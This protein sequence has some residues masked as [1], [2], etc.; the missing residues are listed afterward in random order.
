MTKTSTLSL[1]VAMTLSGGFAACSQGATG[2]EEP[3][4][5]STDQALCNNGNG[6]GHGN[7]LVPSGSRS[8]HLEAR[9]RFNPTQPGADAENGRKKFGIAAD[10]ETEDTSEAL[11]E[12][13]SLPYG[14]T[15]TSNGR[16]CFTCHRGAGARFG[17]PAPPL[18]DSIALTDTLFTGI[19]A[20]AAGD[21][22][23]MDNL[24][25]RGLIK[26][27]PNR[28]NPQRDD[29][30]PYKQVFFWR[31]SIQ[32]VNVGFSNGFLNDGRGRVMFETARGAVFSHTQSTDGR[33]D[34]LFPVP[35]GNDMEAFMFAQV[36][37]PALN[38][39]RDPNDPMYDTLVNDPYYTVPIFT[40]AQKRG[41]KVFDKYCYSCHNTPNVFNGLENIEALGTGQSERSV[42][43]PGFAP[44]V[45]KFYNVG[46]AEANTH[47]LRFTRYT[48]S[49]FAPIVLPLA[50]EDGTTRNLTVTFD[51][52]LAAST[53]RSEDIGRFKVP[54]LRGIKDAAPYFHDNS[55]A[56]LEEVVDYFNSPQYN[57]SADGRDYPIHLNRHQKQDLIAFLEQL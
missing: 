7:K 13:A 54:Q 21:P 23:A 4:T 1:V 46:V 31:K 53:A 34:D 5:S 49:G 11:F 57:H 27:R 48:G 38:A 26:Y 15:V 17:L 42:D 14:G 10:L 45:G 20:D 9:V 2:S 41:K 33:F 40:K 24:N 52:G 16:S 22:D 51:V 12:G 3:V 25:L 8:L 32:L 6:N 30:D 55:A 50:N 44:P 36:S 28:F 35:T 19:D 29:T 18:T 47:N 56:T 39:L 37:D 43:N